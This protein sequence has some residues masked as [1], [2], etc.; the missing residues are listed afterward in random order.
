MQANYSNEELKSFISYKFKD[1]DFL[2]ALFEELDKLYTNKEKIAKLNAQELTDIIIEKGLL[3]RIILRANGDFA[4]QSPQQAR[5]NKQA[6]FTDRKD[7]H[8]KVKL[9]EIKG[10]S[11]I[12][13][14][15]MD[16]EIVVAVSFLGARVKTDGYSLNKS[17]RILESFSFGFGKLLRAEKTVM[18]HLLMLKTPLNFMVYEKSLETGKKVL[19]AIRDIEWRFILANKTLGVNIELPY[20]HDR[21]LSIGIL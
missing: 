17:I 21:S 12:D 7:L 15:Y 5:V 11:A 4:D 8:L 1:K 9:N 13:D 16:K 20:V 10:F 6:P 19:L 18:S 14:T 2:D 3:D